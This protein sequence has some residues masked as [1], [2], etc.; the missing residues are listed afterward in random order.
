MD[1]ADWRKKIDEID[2]KL[3]QLISDRAR[4]AHEI[5]KLKRGLAMPIYEPDR[6]QTVFDQ[7]RKVNPGPLPDRDLLRIYERIMDIMRQIQQ[8][9]IAPE[10][11]AAEATPPDP[12]G[13]ELD[14]DVND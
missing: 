5:G 1:I 7:V 4:A 3:V 2:R 6:E 13:T 14:S 12:G 8:E 9:E 11:L 10:S